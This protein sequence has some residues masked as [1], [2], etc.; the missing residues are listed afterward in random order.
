VSG[1]GPLGGTRVVERAAGLS[2]SYAGFLLAALGA[3]V[4]RVDGADTPALAAG[5]H[6]LRRAKLSVLLDEAA[7]PWRALCA[8]ADVLL[9]DEAAPEVSLA[10]RRI[11]CR[12]SAWGPAGHPLGLPDDEA[13][14]AAITGSQAMQ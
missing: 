5:D 14:V 10:S 3:E 8:S 2:A 1:R 9:A 6:V 11:D 12:V 4:V 13:L 7:T